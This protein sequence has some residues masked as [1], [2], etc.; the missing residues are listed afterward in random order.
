MLLHWRTFHGTERTENA[1][2]PWIGAQQRFTVGALIEELA[3]IRGH[4][5]LSSKST[6]RATQD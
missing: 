4:A 5:L 6:M 2:V 3:G 1:A